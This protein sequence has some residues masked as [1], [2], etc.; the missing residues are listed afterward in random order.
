MGRRAPELRLGYGHLGEPMSPVHVLPFLFVRSARAFFLLVFSNQHFGVSHTTPDTSAVRLR[1]RAGMH[2]LHAALEGANHRHNAVADLSS[3]WPAA[4][5]A[6]A[7]GG[8][9]GARDVGV[10][11]EGGRPGDGEG[12][13]AA[14]GP[15]PSAG[16]RVDPSGRPAWL[17]SGRS[18]MM[19]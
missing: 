5:T 18:P 9:T 2:G 16:G 3:P 10:Q 15:A 12:G 13:G 1:V 11:T 7:T 14:G 6:G 4:G 19:N 17:L 8:R